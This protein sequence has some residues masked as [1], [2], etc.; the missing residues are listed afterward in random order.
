MVGPCDPLHALTS[1]EP[2]IADV[3]AWLIEN[4]LMVNDTI[5]NA[6]VASCRHYP[7][8]TFPPEHVTND[9]ILHSAT[10]KN[11]GVIIDTNMT[12][13]FCYQTVL[14]IPWVYA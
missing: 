11:M 14:F 9:L 7:I 5:I 4:F 8:I 10:F 1:V 3:R 13:K 2:L 12:M 6:I